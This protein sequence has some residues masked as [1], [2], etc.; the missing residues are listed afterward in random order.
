[1]ESNKITL[2]KIFL[3]KEFVHWLRMGKLWTEIGTDIGARFIAYPIIVI[4]VSIFHYMFA[5]MHFAFE[6]YLYI[7]SREQFRQNLLKMEAK[8]RELISK[9][10]TPKVKK[11]VKQIT[12]VQNHKKQSKKQRKEQNANLRLQP[13]YNMNKGKFRYTQHRG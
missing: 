4:L 5:F 10:H 2:L 12:S 7:S 13:N 3:L 11:I 6:T 8:T 9:L 1:M